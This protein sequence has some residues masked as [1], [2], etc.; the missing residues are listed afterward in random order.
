MVVCVNT[1]YYISQFGK[2]FLLKNWNICFLSDNLIIIW[3]LYYE[4]CIL[5][6][7]YV[8]FLVN[9]TFFDWYTYL[10]VNVIYPYWKSSK[11]VY[12]IGTIYI[13]CISICPLT[14]TISFSENLE[15]IL[16][17]DGI[18]KT[19]SIIKGFMSITVLLK[20][21]AHVTQVWL[22]FLLKYFL[23]GWSWS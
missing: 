21:I 20:D 10:L 2:I 8:C 9:M 4:I 22:A 13:Y 6:R 7:K 16:I 15:H 14:Y 23:K 3:G 12:L 1:K 19:I 5:N 11:Y 18:D 17:L